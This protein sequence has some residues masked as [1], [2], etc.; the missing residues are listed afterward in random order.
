MG[1]EFHGLSDPWRPSQFW[2]TFAQARGPE[3]ARGSLGPIAR[4]KPGI[5]MRE[6][7]AIVATQ[8]TQIRR[9][10]RYRDNAEYV[11]LA[12]NDTRMPFDPQASLIPLRLAA[13]MTVVVTTVLLVAAVNA[14]G[15]T[16]ARGVGRAGELAVRRALGATGW[17]IGRKLLTESVLLSVVAG[18]GGILIARWVLDLFRFYTPAQFAVDVSM[19]AAALLFALLTGAGVG[20]VIGMVPAWR[21]STTDLISALPGSAVPVARRARVRLRYF[22]MIP[23]VALSLM[24]LLVAGMQ[25]RALMSLERASI[26]YRTDHLLA[27]GFELRDAPGDRGRTMNEERQ[28]ERT[29]NMYTQLLARLTAGFAAEAAVT[30]ALPLRAGQ[31]QNFTAVARDDAG[32]EDTGRGATSRVA[33]SPGYFRLMGITVLSGRDF[34]ERDSRTTPRVAVISAAIGRR[35]WPGRDPLGRFV[36]ARNNFP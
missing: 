19:D 33:V 24:L 21:A 14:A 11:A 34:D 25:A 29:R 22:V 6:A 5:T 8:G 15:M 10:L 28:A 32:V 30:S 7:Q 26:G 35:L 27:V 16:L 2:V 13:A 23:Q 36:A 12:V 31:S 3:H 20:L 9:A 4:L 1:P 17:R 18:A